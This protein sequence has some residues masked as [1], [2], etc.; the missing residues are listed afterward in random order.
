MLAIG[1]P[2]ATARC[3]KG[4]HQPQE[5]AG[6]ERTH[7]SCIGS[8]AYPDQPSSSPSAR[9]NI[10]RD[11]ANVATTGTCGIGSGTPIQRIQP[12]RQDRDARHQKDDRRV[13]DLRSDSLVIEGSLQ[14]LSHARR[15]ALTVN[16]NDGRCGRTEDHISAVTGSQVIADIGLRRRPT[17]TEGKERKPTRRTSEGTCIAMGWYSL[18]PYELDCGAFV[19]AW[20][21]CPAGLIFLR[22]AGMCV[23][24]LSL[25]DS[26]RSQLSRS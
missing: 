20:V 21:H 1:E 16:E 8:M 9:M 3:A 19:L 7:R 5:N 24:T 17:R 4:P 10:A 14:Q 23:A 11:M 22:L 6:W 12:T 25:C 2:A 18:N 26:A 15:L 13:P